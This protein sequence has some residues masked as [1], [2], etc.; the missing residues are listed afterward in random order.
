MRLCF[1]AAASWVVAAPWLAAQPALTY[2]EV[3][4][5]S[6]CLGSVEVRST[7]VDLSQSVVIA[8]LADTFGDEDRTRFREEFTTYYQKV[9][10]KESVRLAI[11]TGTGVQF[12]GP[13]RTRALLKSALDNLPSAAPNAAQ[14]LDPLRFY[15]DM[16][17][18]A[19]QLG[20]GWLT[21]VLAGNF[22]GVPADL[23]PYTQAWLATQLRVARLR[24]HYWTPSG[25][26]SAILDGVIPA[27]TGKRLAGGLMDLL[28]PSRTGDP[29]EVSWQNP[30]P[31]ESFRLCST[32]LTATGP[33]GESSTVIPAILTAAG[34]TAPSIERY[35][36]WQQ[37][38]K[39]VAAVLKQPQLSDTD[40]GQAGSD[41]AIALEIN[42][43]Y[44][45]AF[46][47][48]AELYRKSGNDSKLAQMLDA[49]TERHP[50][51]IALVTEIGQVRYRMSDWEAADRA[52]LRARELK[53]GDATV[54]EE[55]LR[56]RLTR[57][58]DR[59]ALPY[60]EER[61]ATGPP[62]QDLWLLRADLS[63]RLGD[64]E[65]NA[66]S[67][68][69][70]LTLG[71][72]PLE[73]R[74]GLIRL[75]MGH[76]QPEK[77]LTQV[78]AV[79]AALPADQTIREEYARF[80]DDLHQPQ[81]ALAAWKRILE[82]SPR[83]EP[84][85]Y[86]I[87]RILVDANSVQE[88]LQAAESGLEA[89][90]GSARLYVTKSELQEK[91]N[92]FYDSRRTLRQ[93]VPS[94]SDGSLLARLAEIEDRGGTNAA[95]YYQKLAEMSDSSADQAQ[96]T[97]ALERGRDAALRDADGERAKWFQDR[98][99][100]DPAGSVATRP[101]TG[102]T[103]IPGGL[104][105][106]GFI[107]RSRTS[108]PD[109]FLVEYARTVVRNLSSGKKVADD[110]VSDITEH[111][112]R[113]TELAAFGTRNGDHVTVTLNVR[114]K[115]GQR[116][117]EKIL[118]LLGWK[119]QT[120]KQGVK[121]TPAEKGSRAEH[122]ET[123]S[124][125]A[126]NEIGM[127]EALEADKPFSFDIPY[128]TATVV[129]GEED[130]RTQFYSGKKYLGGLAE[131]L[132]NDQ[133]LAEV[134]VGVGQM[135]PRT[136]ETLA[137]GVSLKKLADDY[138][139]QLL[140]FSS[141]MAVERGRVAV[142]GGI[143]AVPLWT[144]LVRANPNQPGP[145]FRALL[146][147][148]NGK[149]LAFYAAVGSLDI[150]HQ[151]FFTRT[152]SRLAK[153][154]DLFKDAP[155]T[156]R[157]ASRFIQAGTFVA[158]L[159]ELPLDEDGN[160]DFPGSPEVWMVAKGQSQSVAK[161]MKKVKRT[162]APEIE[163]EILL[164][165]ARTKYKADRAEHSELDNFLAVLHI[166]AHRTDP[167]DEGSAL[168]LAQHYD[169]NEAAYPYFAALPGLEQKHF[170]QF[171]AMSD[172]LSSLD[173]SDKNA[174]LASVN[175][176]IKIL[177][178]A[179]QAGTLNEK[180]AAELFGKIVERFQQATSVAAQTTLSIELAREILE[181]AGAPKVD[182]DSAMRDML[183]GAS[184]PGV[185]ILGKTV[186][187]DSAKLRRSQYD[188]VLEL[189]KVPSLA[190]VLALFDAARQVG[191]GKGELSGPIGV[192]ESKAGGL[193]P[194]EVPK[195][196]GLK[197]KER[198]LIA[199]FDPKRLQEIVKDLRDKVAKKKINP[200]DLEK[201]SQEYLDEM[202]APVRWALE[203]IVYAYYL[204]PDD[205]V[206]SEDPLLLRKHQFW[207][208]PTGG[209]KPRLHE[210]AEVNV[211]SER[212]GS[213]FSGGFA[214]FGD[215]AGQA[216]AQSAKLGGEHGQAIV[217]KQMAALRATDWS[218]L[219][220]EDLRLLSLKVAVARE[221]IVRA[222]SRADVQTGLF[223]SSLGLLSLTRRANLVEALAETDWNAVWSSVTLSDLYFLGDRYLE[224]YKTDPW[225]SPA[226]RAL[227]QV[228]AHNDGSR[229]AWL[230][231]EFDDL[232]L[233]SHPHLRTAPPYEDLEKE[234]LPGKVAERSAEFKLYLAVVADRSGI[235][236]SALGS[237]AEPAARFVFKRLQLTDIYDWRST[238]AAYASLDAQILE[239]VLP[240]Q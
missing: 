13:F 160:I 133:E 190:T 217:G 180:Q 177:C 127:Q 212:A 10:N 109:R 184:S 15:P 172:K 141:A 131:A 20:T 63:T 157:S 203:G 199:G 176:L 228:A 108:S 75:Y 196:K 143:A 239:E 76:Q 119:M 7:P 40:A 11:V 235:P 144:A 204:S 53:P 188:Q 99:P 91:L 74:T 135:D 92:Q 117:A 102:T 223:E 225:Q 139:G 69:H 67:L 54:S 128:E 105:A 8:F 58:D 23:S 146:S 26:A 207:I 182:P 200:K 31:P 80:L 213:Y 140:R 185:V 216:A 50:E 218:K 60:L 32:T 219:Q 83:Y 77:A 230:G 59:G 36:L 48:G 93:A 153:F 191:A 71:G 123:A 84:A 163:D 73:R 98:L 148:D 6:T 86:R 150:R 161:L 126:I 111:F 121:L 2:S 151:L 57:G 45:D 178:L 47:M 88:A 189:Q 222:A 78:R 168:T 211:S 49:L 233:C 104:S 18:A 62:T 110:Y 209:V 124:A 224:R 129:L 142:P 158:F 201:L 34:V 37:K 21:V 35:G 66:D 27:T 186:T 96:R 159:A 226:T 227:R 4:R 85:H 44:E 154:Y 232:F 1:L 38:I 51:D 236:A 240:K 46:R 107:A 101:R 221:W 65:R 237:L 132:V 29:R 106:L 195:T 12:N 234:V 94:V 61:L 97:A 145:F 192:L 114:D 115:N 138:S 87:T 64:W 149:L 79:A 14:A 197:D 41:L 210:P 169:E 43:R 90:P 82:V 194:V 155:E 125:L 179:S 24:L 55:L 22:P 42:P 231:P 39:A 136:A 81:E 208:T 9:P 162:A 156:Q 30:V 215:A 171:F 214:S 166:D 25:Q 17:T 229:L 137:A 122:H 173:D 238:L 100:P 183:L 19:S 120:N 164:R 33:N 113:V 28:E 130:W 3:A 116:N 170:D 206:V 72:L 89:A 205:L 5:G 152:P 52:L 181:R 134:Y 16:A 95:V 193:F 187:V 68:E 220:D 118:N 167:L 147:R 175:S 112:R 56:I 70:A 198:D 103:M 202:N 174:A 165:L